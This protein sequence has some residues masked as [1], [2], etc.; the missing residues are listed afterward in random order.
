MRKNKAFG[1][2]LFNQYSQITKSNHKLNIPYFI[3][4]D[5]YLY[6]WVDL[7]PN[8]KV[9][10]IYSGQFKQPQKLLLEDFITINKRYEQLRKMMYTKLDEEEILQKIKAMDQTNKFNTEHIVPQSW[11]GAKEPMKGDLHHLFV[12]E[13]QCNALRSNYPF[14]DHSF[15]EPE[16]PHETIRNN[17]GVL[18]NDY[19]EPEYGKGTVSRAM[20]YFFIRYPKAIK[21]KYLKRVKLQTLRKWNNQFPP[22]LYEKHRNLA[23]YEIQGNRNPFID[24]P[25]LANNIIF[26]FEK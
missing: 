6:T 12:C 8:G 17:C 3:S 4:K 20:F 14:D 9:K 18:H 24:D 22:G 23:I 2:E 11:Y 25:E 1:S 26:P 21:R 5:V 16:S 13:P 15:Y 7:R 10:S 19:F